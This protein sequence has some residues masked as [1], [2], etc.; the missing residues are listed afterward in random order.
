MNVCIF[1]ANNVLNPFFTSF[2][3]TLFKCHLSF[4][5]VVHLQLQNPF[6]FNA[7]Y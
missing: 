5:R 2:S 7:G 1:Y 3:V 6:V 4:V